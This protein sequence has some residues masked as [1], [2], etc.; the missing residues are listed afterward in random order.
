MTSYIF[1][2]LSRMLEAKGLPFSDIHIQDGK[3]IYT[4]IPAGIRTVDENKRLVSQQDI[5]AFLKNIDP[6]ASQEDWVKRIRNGDGQFNGRAKIGDVNVR[7][8]LFDCIGATGKPI[9]WG[10]VIRILRNHIPPFEEL[11]LP[12]EVKALVERENGIIFVT[13]IT[14]SGKTTTMA[15]LIDYVNK[16]F[17]H[18]IVMLEDPIEYVHVD[19][20][21]LIRQRQLGTDFVDFTGGV[22]HAMRQDP[23]IIVIGEV[24]DLHSLRGAISAANSGHLV[25]TSMHTVSAT[26]TV[27]RVI[28]FYPHEE[29]E[30]G[31]K[32]LSDLLIA[33]ISQKLLPSIDGKRSYLAHEIM[34]KTPAIKSLIREDKTNQIMNEMNKKQ[35]LLHVMETS[36]ASL[37]AGRCISQQV[38][39]S[40][41]PNIALLAPQIEA[42]IKESQ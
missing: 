30:I 11:G 23:N 14:G 4:R 19:K 17:A 42:A 24:N 13:G 3:P 18:H 10:L 38:A 9:S 34:E 35:P 41:S 27:N 2:F 28:D 36:L 8:A 21:S 32:M 7:I 12:P 26:E 1:E 37:V 22:R 15:S 40:A 29:K 16:N 6:S 31:R 25:I 20:C 33:V 39:E 5:L